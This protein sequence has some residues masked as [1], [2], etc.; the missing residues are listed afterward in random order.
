MSEWV[1][2]W[3]VARRPE[4]KHISSF[5]QLSATED[6]E[7]VQQMTMSFHFNIFW[8]VKVLGGSQ[9][10]L[11]TVL[12]HKIVSFCCLLSG[13]LVL[14]PPKATKHVHRA[15]WLCCTCSTALRCT[16]LDCG[17]WLAAPAVSLAVEANATSALLSTPAGDT[18][19]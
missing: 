10:H 9:Y 4:N 17:R 2:H 7:R 1:Q 19:R 16:V 8:P 15:S 18:R 14:T 3:P 11:L 12:H 6:N 13:S 5:C